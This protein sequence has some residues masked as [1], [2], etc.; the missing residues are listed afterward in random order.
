[1]FFIGQN[2]KYVHMAYSILEFLNFWLAVVD[3]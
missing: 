2:L 1:M 3:I